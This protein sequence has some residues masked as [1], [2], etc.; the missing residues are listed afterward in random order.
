MPRGCRTLWSRHAAEGAEG[1]QPAT[2]FVLNRHARRHCQPMHAAARPSPLAA[3]RPAELPA[4]PGRAGARDGAQE[5]AG[6]LLPHCQSLQVRPRGRLGWAAKGAAC[7]RMLLLPVGYCLRA[8]LD[9]NSSPAFRLSCADAP[10]LSH[11]SLQVHS[12]DHV[13]LLWFPARHHL[14]GEACRAR[15]SSRARCVTARLPGSAPIQPAAGC[16]CTWL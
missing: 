7:Q 15:V 3:P 2:A 8:Q 11:L 14:G 5:G 10:V 4:A 1:W 6:G 13:Q 16:S 12:E 9:T